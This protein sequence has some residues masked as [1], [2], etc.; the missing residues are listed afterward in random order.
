MQS[1]HEGPKTAYQP[2]S[3]ISPFGASTRLLLLNYVQE[4]FFTAVH[5][6]GLL[7][8]HVILYFG[9]SKVHADPKTQVLPTREHGV[10]RLCM[11]D[12]LCTVDIHPIATLE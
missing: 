2:K 4:M 1:N 6:S 12:P 10:P 5:F 7:V 3:L 8:S 11:S 9:T